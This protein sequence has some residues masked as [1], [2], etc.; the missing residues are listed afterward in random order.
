MLEYRMFVLSSPTLDG[1]QQKI[2]AFEVD[3]GTVIKWQFAYQKNE[4][5]DR[6]V[7]FIQGY[8][9]SLNKGVKAA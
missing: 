1:L 3:G 7:M 5:F 9:S 6:Y 4:K 8:K 2:R